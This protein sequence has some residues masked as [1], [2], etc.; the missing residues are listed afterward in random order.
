[1]STVIRITLV[2]I[3]MLATSQAQSPKPGD[4]PTG[5]WYCTGRSANNKGPLYVSRVVK[6]ESRAFR[7]RKPNNTLY[8]DSFGDWVVREHPHLKNHLSCRCVGGNFKEN[9]AKRAEA[10][11]VNVAKKDGR[12]VVYV[13]WYPATLNTVQ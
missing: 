2:L 6:T 10:N 3:T 12:S 4:D 5:F 11:E 9:E 7:A 8:E 13:G 1:M